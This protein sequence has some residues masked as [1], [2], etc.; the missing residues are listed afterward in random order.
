MLSYENSGFSLNANVRIPSW[1]REGFERLI[2]GERALSTI[3]YKRNIPLD[4]LFQAFSD[5]VVGS[6]A[7]L[8]S[9]FGMVDRIA[10]IVIV[11]GAVSHKCDEMLE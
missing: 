5:G 4:G 7:D 10:R 11:P 8:F 9:D 3:F 6:P 2:R 1:D